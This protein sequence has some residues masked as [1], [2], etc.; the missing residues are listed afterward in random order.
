M[1]RF[2]VTMA[3]QGVDHFLYA[4]VT[5]GSPAMAKA[6]ALG[7]FAEDLDEITSGR[8]RVV[9]CHEIVQVEAAA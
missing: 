5:A 7:R 2:I 3:R 8:L 4:R 6:A 9:P 1:R